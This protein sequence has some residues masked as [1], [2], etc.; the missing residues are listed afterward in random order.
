MA[1]S[2]ALIEE[3]RERADLVGVISEHVPL[4]KR[5]TNF[6]GLCPFHQEKSPSFT[7]NPQKNIWHCF[8]CGEGG[9]VYTFLMKVNNW[10]FIEAV[11]NV[12]ER[13]GISLPKS[14]FEKREK[15][16]YGF[17]YRQLEKE[18]NEHIQELASTTGLAARKYLASRE[19]SAELINKFQ[20]G[21]ASS[22]RFQ[23]RLIF[24]IHDLKD[25]CI[26]FGGRILA[27][28][29]QTAKY[30][31]SSESP[32]YT[33]GNHL[34]ALNIAKNAIQKKDQ[35]V[36]VEGYMDVIACHQ[37]G[38]DNAVGVLGTALTVSQARLLARFTKNII[39]VFDSDAAGR[40]ATLRSL[41]L[42][43][44]DELDLSVAILPGKD[45]D[46]TIRQ[47]GVEKLHQAF[48][49]PVPRIRYQLD[50]IISNF[51]IDTPEGKSDAVKA[52]AKLLEQENSVLQEEYKNYLAKV[53]KIDYFIL[54]GVIKS[55]AESKSYLS[56]QNTKPASKGIKIALGLLN[57]S[58]KDTN[59]R[60]EVFT[61]FVPS[62][63]IEASLINLASELQ[64]SDLDMHSFMNT[65]TDP[66]LG[67]KA[68]EIA[69]L[70][71]IAEYQELISA[72]QKFKKGV[73][74]A[75]I[76]ERMRT[77]EQSNDV[78]ALEKLQAEYHSLL[79][80]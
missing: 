15:D 78:P 25:R 11:E 26:A 18:K 55:S 14:D 54:K 13:V 35:A 19:L 56:Q 17:L 10:P 44:N 16:K 37:A 40:K 34:Y 57:Q 61:H 63:F 1:I 71:G 3:I 22:G 72:F 12:A 69:F 38:I 50:E 52:C 64:S 66:Q 59:I 30:I 49:A 36:V 48:A 45:P 73:L 21:Y 53:L 23:N 43:A 29:E 79:T 31:N 32:V 47:F 51:K 8:G 74:Q 27:D 39:L 6:L 80:K 24:P 41:E 65:L 70:D 28:Q 20:L 46:E 77:A 5:G 33:K 67:K 2:P 42:L 58:L 75:E 7:V 60:R 9:N 76:K 68:A 62:D 4:K